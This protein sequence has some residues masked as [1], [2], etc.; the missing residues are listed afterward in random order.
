MQ[1]ID[2]GFVAV[3]EAN[4]HLRPRIGNPDEIRSNRMN[5]TLESFKFRAEKPEGGN[6]EAV[7]GAV[8]TVLNEEAVAGAVFGNKGGINI[9]VTYEAFGAKIF[10]EA[11]QEVIFAQHLKESGQGPHWLSVPLVMASHAWENG[12]NEQSHQD[13]S[14]AEAMFGEMADISRVMF[15]PDYNTSAVVIN[16]LY[17]TQGQI[18]TIVASKRNNHDIFT[19]E[20]ARK[21]YRDGGIR[22]PWFEHKADEAKLSLIAIGAYQLIDVV[23]AAKRLKEAD[24][25]VSVACLLEPG[26]FRRA[27]SA[28]ERD[29]MASK[30]VQAAI[31]PSSVEHVGFVVHTRPEILVGALH[32]WFGKRSVTQFGFLNHGGT[33]DA[34]GLMYVNHSSWAHILRDAATSLGFDEGRVLHEDERAALDGKRSPDGVI[35]GK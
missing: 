2:L 11:R 5:E 27:R 32:H 3:A 34:D 31:L 13:P 30:E 22:L 9:L 33:L 19:E 26:K 16:E 15:P 14:M 6:M 8:V 24:I 35:R 1:A 4:S 21:L 17:Q 12:K 29:H 10:G 23:K 25:P 18:W 28:M 20:E 7:D